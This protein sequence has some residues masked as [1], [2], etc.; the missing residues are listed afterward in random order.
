MKK[1]IFFCI[2]LLS[3]ILIGCTDVQPDIV[4]V[5]YNSGP[6]ENF[7]I[8]LGGNN[9]NDEQTVKSLMT[10]TAGG[11]T[12]TEIDFNFESFT[13]NSDTYTLIGFSP[14]LVNGQT[15]YFSFEEG[16]FGNYGIPGLTDKSSPGVYTVTV[17]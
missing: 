14:A 2:L 6:P 3:V 7:V 1:T 11:F 16:A 12:G 10:I 9:R 13:D 5:E 17:P 15:Y 4:R 8:T